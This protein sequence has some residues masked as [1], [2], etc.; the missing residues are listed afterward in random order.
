MGKRTI[1]EKLAEGMGLD[2]VWALRESLL[3]ERANAAR[4][5]RENDELRAEVARIKTCIGPVWD[6][7]DGDGDRTD[8]AAMVA[9]AV[10]DLQKDR[11]ENARLRES[12]YNIANVAALPDAITA[13]RIAR[14]ALAKGSDDE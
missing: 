1:T 8:L 3:R 12:L 13:I 9:D 7:Y 11:A 14:A 4:L 10:A 2:P 6:W 5:H